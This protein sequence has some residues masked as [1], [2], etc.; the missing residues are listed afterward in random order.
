[1]KQQQLGSGESKLETLSSYILIVGVIASVILA[2]IGIIFF[3]QSLG[4][5]GISHDPSFYIHGS[6]FFSFAWHQLTGGQSE[7]RAVTFMAAGVIVLVLTPYV[8]VFASVAYFAWEKNWKYV[9]ITL[10]V[11]VVV[12]LSLLLH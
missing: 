12:T 3:A 7:Q 11:L 4:G 6:N 2:I 8:R 1:M 10:F 9:V 5:V